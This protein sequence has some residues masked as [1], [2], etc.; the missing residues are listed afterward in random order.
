MRFASRSH[1]SAGSAIVWLDVEGV[2]D[3]EGF[4][5]KGP[6]PGSCCLWKGRETTMPILAPNPIT[7]AKP[8][9]QIPSH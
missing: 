2:P 6:S 4:P 1:G 7:E 9:P 5:R 3:I 8:E